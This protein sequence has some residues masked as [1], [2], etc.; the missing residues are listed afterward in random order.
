[1]QYGIFLYLWTASVGITVENFWELEWNY[2]EKFFS[3]KQTKQNG[4][5]LIDEKYVCEVS[6]QYLVAKLYTL[7]DLNFFGMLPSYQLKV[8]NVKRF[9][10]L[11]QLLGH[12]IIIVGEHASLKRSAVCHDRFCHVE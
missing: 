8:L 6:I 10:Q 2:L 5:G 12:H 7:Q 11:S 1:M 4:N 3:H 9:Q